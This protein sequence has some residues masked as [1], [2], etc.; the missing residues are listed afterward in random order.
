MENFPLPFGHAVLTMLFPHPQPWA[1]LIT[2]AEIGN[3][4]KP[5]LAP[6]R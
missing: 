5:D 4:R 2:S 3:L 1:S 6:F